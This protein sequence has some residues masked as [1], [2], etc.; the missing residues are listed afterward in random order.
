[1]KGIGHGMI[2]GKGRLV[3]VIKRDDGTVETFYTGR[4]AEGVIQK[5]GEREFICINGEKRYWGGIID[6]IPNDR[7]LQLLRDFTF[8]SIKPDGVRLGIRKMV[9]YLIRNAGCTIVAH[10]DIT[11]DERLVRK[12]Y[13]YFFTEEWERQ[14][15]EY[16]TSGPSHCFLVTGD[17]V[18]RKMYSLKHAIRQLFGCDGAPVVP[19]FVHCAERQI[20]AV[21]QAL[22]FFSLEELVERVGLKNSNKGVRLK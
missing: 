7:R 13:P 16:M 5:E 4:D 10:K 19:S 14:L 20:F 8:L 18:Q 6:P 1:M 3:Q 2:D 17:N 11:F 15:V 22:M 12:M 21:Q 9:E